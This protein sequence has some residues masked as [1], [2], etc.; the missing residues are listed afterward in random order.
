MVSVFI[1]LSYQLKIKR[2]LKTIVN[3]CNNKYFDHS[4]SYPEFFTFESFQDSKEQK[5]VLCKSIVRNV[6]L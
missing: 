1:L 4:T 3:Q 2:R 5:K 6:S